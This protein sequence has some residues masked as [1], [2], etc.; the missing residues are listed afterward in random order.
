M[1]YT[2]MCCQAMTDA[3]IERADSSE[4]IKFCIERCPYESGC[5]LVEGAAGMEAALRRKKR[6]SFAE[7]L[8]AHGISITDIALIMRYSERTIHGY[9]S[10]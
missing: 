5:V 1:N 3:G 10:Q 9:L 6:I 2:T 8:Y 4:G 7:R